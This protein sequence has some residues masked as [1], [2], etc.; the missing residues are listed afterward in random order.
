M[1]Y[2]KGEWKAR[3]LLPDKYGIVTKK[4]WEVFTPEY[5]VVA[6]IEHGAPIRREGDAR[7]IA[8]APDMYEALKVWQKHQQ[9]THGHYC[10]ECA[11]LL[12]KAITKAEGK[13]A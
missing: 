9:R 12:E 4:G 5:D 10:S 3:K 1:N 2:T 6:M 8:S 7:L 13:D 11:D